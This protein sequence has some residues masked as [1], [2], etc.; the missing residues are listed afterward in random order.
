MRVDTSND[1]LEISHSP[2]INPI[3]ITDREGKSPRLC[4]DARRVNSTTIQ[5][6]EQTQTLNELLKRFH[7]AKYMTSVELAQAFLKINLKKTPR[8]Y[9]AFLFE[10]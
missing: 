7:G 2:Y 10:Y 6:C 5:D 8:P 3:T 9:N 4:A 1:V